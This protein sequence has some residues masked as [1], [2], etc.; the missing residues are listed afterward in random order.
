MLS[1]HVCC[2]N[3]NSVMSTSSCK[4]ALW[5]LSSYCWHG[6]RHTLH[7]YYEP[8]LSHSVILCCLMEVGFMGFLG[9]KILCCVGTLAIM[10]KIYL[11]I[12]LVIFVVGSWQW[13]A[14]KEPKRSI[15]QGFWMKV[16]YNLWID[17][18]ETKPH[19]N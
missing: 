3:K 4:W 16:F 11:G 15:W 10:D 13:V 1:F 6:D 8:H 2:N 9:G 19:T 5:E 7:S 12:I 14:L 17:K 18:L